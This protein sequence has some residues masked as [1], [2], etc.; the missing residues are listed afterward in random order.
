MTTPEDREAPAAKL[1]S[2]ERQRAV[3]R[4][5]HLYFLDG[6]TQA[7]V[8]ERL[9]CTRW[10]VGRLLKEGEDSGVVDIRI[11]HTQAR[12]QRL[13]TELRARFGLVD[14]QVVG[15]QETSGQTMALVAQTAADYLADI[16]PRPDVVALAWGRTTSAVA[17]A[18]VA[19]WSPGTRVVQAN[20][21]PGEVDELLGSGAARL[22]AR[23]G[24]GAVTVFDEVLESSISG[25]GQGVSSA[26][27]RV[28]EEAEK[29]DVVVFSPGGIP[30]S[31]IIVKSGFISLE[32]LK[33]LWR[34][35]ARAN[36][37]GRFIDAH[38]R[39]VSEE[40]E[41]RVP[42]MSLESLSRVQCSLAVSSG[43]DKVTPLVATLNGGLATALITDSETAKALLE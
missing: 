20:A 14:V 23:K 42:A 2:S 17:R 5:A 13:E 29:A 10:T 27:R 35:G 12:V 32:E 41:D 15:A 18:A 30:S 38:A 21:A 31:S 9:G 16:R 6:L 22:L 39:P 36:I 3:L 4:A 25:V 33:E 1:A 28:V 11:R 24:P 34:L 7:A 43:P 40:L 26:S 37:L 19:R 8:A